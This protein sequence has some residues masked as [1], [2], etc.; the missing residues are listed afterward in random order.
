METE[1]TFCLIKPESYIFRKTGYIKNA[2][3]DSGLRIINHSQIRLSFCDIFGLYPEWLPRVTMSLRFYPLF[4]VDLFYLEGENSIERMHRLKRNIR[5]E[6][7]GFIFG[8]YIHAPDNTAEF[9]R[10]RQIFSKRMV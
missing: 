1:T 4:D 3:N 9:N 5:K 2:L 10:A 6:L 7:G 8:G